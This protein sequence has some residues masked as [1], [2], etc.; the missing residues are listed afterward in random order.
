MT[1]ANLYAI[2]LQIYLPTRNKYIFD[3]FAGADTIA[4]IISSIHC[5]CKHISTRWKLAYER[6]LDGY[7][8]GRVGLNSQ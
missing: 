7:A 4:G 3:I 6:V 8:R 5:A 2:F 1:Y